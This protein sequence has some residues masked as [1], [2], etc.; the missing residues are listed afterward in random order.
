MDEAETTYSMELPPASQFADVSCLSF[1]PQFGQER[2][3]C[4]AAKFEKNLTDT[5][6]NLY[7]AGHLKFIKHTFK[8][9]TNRHYL[10]SVVKAEMRKNVSYQCHIQLD[11]RGALL[12]AQ[13]ECV[14][15]LGPGAHCKHMFVTLHALQTFLSSGTITLFQ[16]V[17]S[18]LQIHHHP[19]TQY[20]G[21]PI[22][23]CDLQLGKNVSGPVDPR[24]LHFRA[25][26]NY[27]SFVNNLIIAFSGTQISSMPIV[28]TLTPANPF[29][30]NNDHHYASRNYFDCR[31][32]DINNITEAEARSLEMK[33]RGQAKSALWHDARSTRLTSSMFGR[34]CKRTDRTDDS[35]LALQILH[36]PNLAKVT[37]IRY[38]VANEPNAIEEYSRQTGDVVHRSG[39]FIH[40]S[41][42]MLASSPDGIVDDD[43]IIEVKCPYSAKDKHI[44]A[45]TVPYLSGQDGSLEL[46]SNHNYY[47]Q[48]QGQLAITNAKACDFVVFTETDMK[49]IRIG[50][51]EKFI[52]DML[53]NLTSFYDKSFRECLQERFVIRRYDVVKCHHTSSAAVL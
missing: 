16:S 50:R 22:V 26:P 48:V 31:V 49:I 20:T 40:P 32:D 7:N 8:Q 34:I 4:H 45:I 6:I 47:Y 46:K 5:H 29:A 9:N 33:T 24:P 28:Q 42:P 21:S 43:I 36:P 53:S 51:D 30:I 19:P 2:I 18:R 10:W 12:E 27:Q 35:K 13:C 39:L 1:L 15:G 44:D 11:S 23:A 17:T 25:D 41:W 38:G 37:A 14:A 52:E 3:D